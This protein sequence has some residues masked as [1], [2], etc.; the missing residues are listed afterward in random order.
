VIAP[1]KPE[2]VPQGSVQAAEC[3]RRS[4]RRKRFRFDPPEILCLWASEPHDLVR[5]SVKHLA[6][7]IHGGNWASAGSFQEDTVASKRRNEDRL[8]RRSG[9]GERKRGEQHRYRGGPF[10]EDRRFSKN[11][12]T[13]RF[14]RVPITSSDPKPQLIHS[15]S[16]VGYPVPLRNQVF[17]ER[18]RDRH[19]ESQTP[20][21]WR[22]ARGRS[23]W[24]RD[25]KHLSLYPKLETAFSRELFS[26]LLRLTML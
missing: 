1:H 25:R 18:S 6:G 23:A 13:P 10:R 19:E 4:D 22:G 16:A 7:Q 9:A 15:A 20:E 17:W 5:C 8:L 24:G 26:T 2:D 11:S 12:G 3:L 21:A 14:R